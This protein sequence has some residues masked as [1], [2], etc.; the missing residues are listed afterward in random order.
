MI[1]EITIIKPYLILKRDSIYSLDSEMF[2]PKR[3]HIKSPLN[4]FPCSTT[5]TNSN[6]KNKPKKI[7]T[8]CLNIFCKKE[9]FSKPIIREITYAYSAA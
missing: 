7:K 5:L 1:K 8:D 2:V 3:I 4:L 6:T 9:D